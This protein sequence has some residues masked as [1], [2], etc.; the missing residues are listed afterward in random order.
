M[1]YK[2]TQGGGMV[3]TFSTW[4]ITLWVALGLSIDAQLQVGG[5]L[6]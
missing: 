5:Q 6:E 3:S 2:N 1:V 4:S